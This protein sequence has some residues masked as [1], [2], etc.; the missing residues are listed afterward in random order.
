MN[1]QR[2]I[3]YTFH[4]LFS[5]QFLGVFSLNFEGDKLSPWPFFLRDNFN[6]SAGLAQWRG[7]AQTLINSTSLFFAVNLFI[8]SSKGVKYTSPIDCYAS[9][10]WPRGTMVLVP[11]VMSIRCQNQHYRVNWAKIQTYYSVTFNVFPH[12][13]EEKCVL[14]LPVMDPFG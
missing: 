4:V 13:T 7:L 3:K 10:N 9:Q 8:N 5:L 6:C 2:A 14:P 12:K 11:P 1:G